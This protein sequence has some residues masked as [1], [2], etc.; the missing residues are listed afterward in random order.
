M[1]NGGEES[2]KLIGDIIFSYLDNE[3][4][5]QAEDATPLK[6]LKNPLISTDSF[7]VTPLFF[8][9]GD[10]G[11]LCVA[12]SCNDIAMMGAKPLYLT[13]S[14]IIEEGFSI[15]DFKKI[16]SSIK[17]ECELN[18]VFVVTGDTKVVPKG[19]CDGIYIN[20]AAV[21]ERIKE[22]SEKNIKEGDVIL[23]SGDIARHGTAIFA[24]REGIGL[25]NSIKSDCASLWG[26]VQ[27]LIKA[28]D[29]KAMR[30]ATRGGVAAVLNEWAK[31][32]KLCFE[33]EESKIAIDEAVKGVCEILGFEP[34]SLANEGTFL[35]VV[36][37][38]EG[39]KALEILKKFNPNASIIGRVSKSYPSKVVLKSEWGTKRF[40]DMPSGEILPRIC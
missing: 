4:L 31:D 27:E 34:L 13:L 14:F 25:E 39:Q 38:E 7:T 26:V 32:R 16:L 33:I 6:S 9:G 17:K 28:V 22:V 21:G 35:A 30:D 3:F 11:K 24:A 1:G 2:G 40:L 29:V 20:T 19:G 18:G 8:N 37:K 10:I 15:D 23:L 5:Q 36:S 12:G